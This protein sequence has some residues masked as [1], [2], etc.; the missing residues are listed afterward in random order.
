MLSLLAA[1]PLLDMFLDSSIVSPIYESLSSL[2][3]HL[4]GQPLA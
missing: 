1:S 3:K 2:A 4:S